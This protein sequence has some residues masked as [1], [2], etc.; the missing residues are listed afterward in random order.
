MYCENRINQKKAA[1]AILISDEVD[2][3]AKNILPETER[4]ILK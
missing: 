2:L 4:G 1:V 3:R